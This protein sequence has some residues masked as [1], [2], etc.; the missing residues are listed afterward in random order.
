MVNKCPSDN[1]SSL[2]S[3]YRPSRPAVFSIMENQF[4]IRQSLRASSRRGYSTVFRSVWVPTSCS[5]GL[6][7]LVHVKV[8]PCPAFNQVLGILSSTIPEHVLRDTVTDTY[9]GSSPPARAELDYRLDQRSTT[10]QVNDRS[11]RRPARSRNVCTKTSSRMQEFASRMSK[12]LSMRAYQ[13]PR[14]CGSRQVLCHRHPV[15]PNIRRAA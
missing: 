1:A 9:E 2:A 11:T 5:S 14:A 10:Q 6:G 13:S 7:L 4:Q 12:D 8:Q 3:R 15:S